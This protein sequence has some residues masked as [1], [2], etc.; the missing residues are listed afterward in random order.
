M[1]LEAAGGE[2]LVAELDG[3]V[4]GCLTTS[5]MHVLQRPKPLGR[6]SMVVVE[7]GLRGRGIGAALVRAA[8][9]S[10]KARG[11]GLVEVT[12]NLRRK[13]AH[14][15]YEQLG[16]ERSSFRFFREL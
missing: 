14:R 9:Q 15:F 12:S 2:V 10:F 5:I 3:R 6:M 16:Y 8:E 7:E 11:C 1:L 13:D 4:V